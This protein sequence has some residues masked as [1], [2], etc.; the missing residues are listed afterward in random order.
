[1]NA[2]AID[3]LLSTTLY[4]WYS[5]V[6]QWMPGSPESLRPCGECHRELAAIIEVGAWPHELVDALVT[7]IDG[8]VRHVGES[9]QEDGVGAD[10]AASLAREV[11][12]GELADHAEDIRDVLE[13][14]IPYRL[15]AF[16]E[17]ELDLARL[18]AL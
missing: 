6:S 10:A 14:C 15:Q 2:L 12:M 17:L 3:D 18:G 1:M 11:V 16:A 5:D 7:A 9:F 4:S 13:Q 8:V